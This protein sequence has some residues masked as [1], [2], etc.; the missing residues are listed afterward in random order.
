[1][2]KRNVTKLKNKVVD[3]VRSCTTIE[4]LDVA[5]RYDRLA[6]K[7]MREVGGEWRN[8][9]PEEYALYNCFLRARQFI[10]LEIRLKK[11]KLMAGAKLW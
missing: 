7:R 9:N 4:Q 11:S 8:I 10:G 1:M 3:V 5:L 6:E 2:N